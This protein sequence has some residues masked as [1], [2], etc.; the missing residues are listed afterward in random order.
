MMTGE[1]PKVTQPGELYLEPGHFE[2]TVS[3]LPSLLL[4]L[5]PGVPWGFG[6]AQTQSPREGILGFCI[7]TN[8]LVQ[9]IQEL[10][11]TPYRLPFMSQ[12]R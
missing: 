5:P 11:M 1:L 6:D 9:H 8:S 3:P 12:S 7:F 4:E 2:S 10:F